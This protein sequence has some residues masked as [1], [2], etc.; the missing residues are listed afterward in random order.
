MSHNG[1]RHIFYYQD[2]LHAAYHRDLLIKEFNMEK[3][4]PLNNI[5]KP[6][7]FVKKI[8]NI[9]VNSK[10]K[11]IDV[12]GIY[13]N[14]MT[15]D[16]YGKQKE[17]VGKTQVDGDIYEY[18]KLNKLPLNMSD[19]YVFITIDGQKYRLHRWVMKYD[20][21]LIVDHIDNDRCNNTRDNLRITDYDKNAQNKK[22]QK[23]ASSKYVGVCHDKRNNTWKA[24]IQREHLGTFKTEELAVIARNKRA[25]ELN[26]LGAFYKI[27]YYGMY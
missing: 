23:N 27:E 16:I 3:L 12:K 7:N 13:S 19:G 22:A 25:T 4:Y 20:G 5:Q 14:P 1:D 8:K 6:N 10:K 11:L 26:A 21:E 24:A 9:K 18:I 17:I 15:I 2:E